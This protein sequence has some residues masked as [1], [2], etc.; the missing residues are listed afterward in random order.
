MSSQKNNLSKNTVIMYVRMA[1]IMLINLYTVRVV[2][3]ALGKIDYGIYDVVAGVVTLIASVSSVLSSS[4]HRYFSF[5]LGQNDI[6]GY[7]SFFSASINVYL[8]IAF[9]ILVVG[10]VIGSF[11]INRY[12]DIPQERLNAANWIYQFALFAFI[13]SLLHSPFNSSIIVHEDMG[14]FAILSISECVLKLTFAIGMTYIAF[15][16]LIFYGGYLLLIAVIV[17]LVNIII[18]V[19]RYPGCKY[20]KVTEPGLYKEFLSF[21]GW[22]LFGTLA[23]LSLF[24]ATTILLN[25]F[26][27]PI[28]S[29]ARAISIQVYSALNSF[30]NNFLMVI[31]PP[32]IKQYA[33]GDF[34]RL[35][36]LFNLSNKTIYYSLLL[37][38]IPILF[39]MDGVLQFWLKT[40]DLQI[41]Y[42]SRLMVVYAI[43]M[44]IGNPITFV[45]QATG[46]IKKYFTRVELFTLL[47]APCTY[48]LFK[49]GFDASFSFWTMIVAAFLSHIVR[50][51]CIRDLY[52]HFDLKSYFLSFIAPS[53]LVTITCVCA[54]FIVEYLLDPGLLR[55]FI[56]TIENAI[57]V[58]FVSYYFGLSEN[59]KHVVISIYER[60]LNKFG[61]YRI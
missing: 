10:E 40:S 25:M 55:F 2:L 49:L 46:K 36:F 52:E 34:V 8:I 13:C 20:I 50:I 41:V 28:V 23:G 26:F 18:S 6:E 7:K 53:I 1:V 30:G 56:L 37:I 45:V 27:G 4:C 24:Q 11:V 48:M 32:L 38:C 61:Y 15:D 31:K 16:H 9:F 60:I 29:A 54:S 3:N 51:V 21:S 17:L 47:C 59:E 33:S 35:N 5:R 42:F 19:R 14:I 57:V 12:L 43:I 22:T 58:L 44:A 39:E